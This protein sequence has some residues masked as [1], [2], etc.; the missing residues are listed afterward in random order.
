MRETLCLYMQSNT[1]RDAQWLLVGRH[2]TGKLHTDPLHRIAGHCRNRKVVVLIPA[3]DVLLTRTQI[4]SRNRQHLHNAIPYALEE[5]LVGDVETQLFALADRNPPGAQSVAVIARDCFDQWLHTLHDAGI[6]PQWMIP[7][8]LALPWQPGS[9]T[10]ARVG[11][12]DGAHLLR[13]G[14]LSGTLIDNGN[15]SLILEKLYAAAADK[16]AALRLAGFD[17]EDERSGPL[18]DWAARHELKLEAFDTRKPL[19]AILAAGLDTNRTINLLQHSAD[20]PESLAGRYLRPFYPA[21][22]AATAWALL[23]IAIL[24]VDYYKTDS[25]YRQHKQ[26][27]AALFRRVFPTQQN[28]Q[29]ARRRMQQ[30]LDRL[31]KQNRRGQHSFIDL[32]GMTGAVIKSVPALKLTHLNYQGGALHL[33]FSIDD[34]GKVDRLEQRLKRSGLTV[35][36]GSSVSNNT[37][38]TMQMI[39][40]MQAG[41]ELR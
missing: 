28:T 31:K 11:T 26:Q 29:Y 35:K 13:T 3:A 23:N 21:L 8:V 20:A 27:A 22:A 40:S 2:K 37:G 7:D 12:R 9:W 17:A 39:V 5:Q 33:R 25:E 18:G 32:L 16:P 10:L 1:A 14:A 41:G 6:R 36:R 19:A 38:Y 4:P 24:I 30:Y 34:L 15:E